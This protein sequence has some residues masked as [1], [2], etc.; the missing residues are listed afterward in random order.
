MLYDSSSVFLRVLIEKVLRK[1]KVYTG[2]INDLSF[3]KTKGKHFLGEK[4]T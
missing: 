2:F 3:L 1:R 4:T